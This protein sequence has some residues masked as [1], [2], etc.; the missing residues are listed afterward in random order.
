MHHRAREDALPSAVTQIYKH[1]TWF[2]KGVVP[3]VRVSVFPFFLDPF[4]DLEEGFKLDL[5][6]GQIDLFEAFLVP[7][8]PTLRLYVSQNQNSKG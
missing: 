3:A 1:A 8:A 2:I 7:L 4:E 6:I 5:S